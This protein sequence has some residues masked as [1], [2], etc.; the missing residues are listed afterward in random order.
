VGRIFGGGGLILLALFM[1]IGFLRAEV[2]S[3]LATTIAFLVAVV[4]PAV[5]GIA[6]LRRPL[7]AGGRLAERRDRLRRQTLDAEV[8]RLAAGRG[9]RLT[10]VEV[11]TELAV[12]TDAARESLDSL[13]RH[14]VA[15]LEVT[16]SGTI[17]YAFR[18]V[19]NL[20]EKERAKGILDE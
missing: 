11:V 6:L 16:D 7:G 10:V 8:L 2:T 4:L 19:Q 5:G 17:V 20:A 15:D 12:S 13:A 1:L 18:D 3:G 9:G 14:E